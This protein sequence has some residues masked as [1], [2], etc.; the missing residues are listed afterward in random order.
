[1][2]LE[3]VKRSG[4]ALQYRNSSAEAVVNLENIDKIFR[5]KR[6]HRIRIM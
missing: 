3:A 5:G 4:L 6:E 2:V 1:L